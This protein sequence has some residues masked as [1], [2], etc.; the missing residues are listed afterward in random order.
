MVVMA[1]VER[2]SALAVPAAA[3]A[4]PMIVRGLA[5]FRVVV[6]LPA[7]AAMDVSP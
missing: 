2:V 3:M 6:V 4:P 1:A 5:T 7:L